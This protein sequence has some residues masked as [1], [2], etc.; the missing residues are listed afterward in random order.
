[1]TVVDWSVV[2][3]N[4][5]DFIYEKLDG[6]V[7]IWSGRCE[8]VK[9]QMC[10]PVESE[11][12]KDVTQE[13]CKIRWETQS[14]PLLPAS[15]P[16]GTRSWRGRSARLKQ[17]SSAHLYLRSNARR[18]AFYFLSPLFFVS[19]FHFSHY[20]H[21][22]IGVS[23]WQQGNARPIWASAARRSAR[24]SRTRSAASR[25]RSSKC[26]RSR[27]NWS[28]FSCLGPHAHIFFRWANAKMCPKLSANC[29]TSWSQCLK[30]P[31]NAGIQSYPILKIPTFL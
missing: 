3:Q 16:S 22:S 9:K 29:A 7:Y 11:E 12:C 24:R 27:S 13:V 31:Q 30:T 20:S 14:S 25:P 18:W 8:N 6:D 15:K 4:Q 19:F 23:R 17:L 21:L 28:V 5:T 26:R 2:G 1:M 10:N